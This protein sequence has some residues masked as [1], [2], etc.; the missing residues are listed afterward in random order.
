[1]AAGNIDAVVA[2]AKIDRKRLDSAAIGPFSLTA[3]GIAS[4]GRLRMPVSSP[5]GGLTRSCGTDTPM[6]P[7]KLT[8]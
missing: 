5:N 4:A 3:I 1:M 8:K 2:Q 6:L 7:R